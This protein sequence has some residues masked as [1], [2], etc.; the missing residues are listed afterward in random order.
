MSRRNHDVEGTGMGA[1]GRYARWF[2]AALALGLVA[3][4]AQQG[5]PRPE[6]AADTDALGTIAAA[7][8]TAPT[9][10]IVSPTANQKFPGASS[11]NSL[12][13]TVSVSNVTLGPGANGI[14]YFLD[15]VALDTV[16]DTTPYLIPDFPNGRRHIAAWL[17]D[18]S[19]TPLDV[20]TAL[21]S[22]YVSFGLPCAKTNDC[23]DGLLCSA[24]ACVTGACRFGPLAG[25]CDQDLE[26]P[27]GWHCDSN[28]CIE[29]YEDGECDDGD[30][31]TEDACGGDGLCIHAPID[32]CC[33]NAKQCNDND[34]CTTDSCVVDSHFCLHEPV[35]DPLCCN[36]DEDCRPAD[37][38]KLYICYVNTVT[39][40]GYHRCRY[41]PPESGCC[42]DDTQCADANPC[43]LDTCVQIDPLDARGNCVHEPDPALTECCLV[44]AD[45][46]DADPST[47]DACVAN[48]C[49]HTPS[50][51]WCPL[52]AAPALVINEL[53]VA[54]GPVDDAAGE[55]IE[56]YNPSPAVT[57]NMDGWR[58][59]TS[60]GES[61]L[62]DQ[63][64]VSGGPAGL[65]VAPR[66]YYVFGRTQS[67]SVNGGFIP[68]SAYGAAISLPDPFETGAAVVH[69]VSLVSDAGVVIDELTYDSSSWPLIDGHSLERTHPHADGS[70]VASWR[71]AGTS[72]QPLLDRT[73]GD[74][75]LGLYG[76]PKNKNISSF[77]GLPST[78]CAAEPGAPTCQGGVCNDR[79]QCEEAL[80][81]GCCASDADCDDFDACTTDACDVG[82]ETCLPAVPI[83]DCCNTSDQCD[84]GDPCNLD[85]C[86]AHECR[87]SPPII[88]GCCASDAD[89]QDED[90]CA[91]PHCNATTDT[92][93]PP[94]PASPGAG[95]QCCVADVDCSDGQANTDDTCDAATHLCVFPPNGEQCTGAA[96]PCDD[97]DPCTTDS[98][99]VANETCVHTPVP[100]CCTG[101]GECPDDGDLCTQTVCDFGSLSCQNVALL[102]CCNADSDCADTDDCTVDIC[103][104]HTCH[105]NALPG[106]C[107]VDGDC[108]DSQ[109]CTTDTC[110]G[111]TCEH[112]TV[113][114]C[115][116]PG[117]DQ[118][119]LS[120]QCGADPDGAA[121]CFGWECTVAG[122]CSVVENPDCCDTAAD[123]DDGSP[124]TT[125]LCPAA[126]KLCKH[127]AVT[128][129]GCCSSNLDC[130]GS[131]YCGANAVCTTKQPTGTSCSGDD[132]CASD[133]CL[134]GLCTTPAGPGASCSV[135]QAC[136]SGYC[137]DGVCCDGACGG[138][139]QACDLAG[140]EGLCTG[141]A[142][143]GQ[144]CDGS[145]ECQPKKPTGSGCAGAG[146][147]ASGVC[148]SAVCCE[149]ACGAGQYC[150]ASGTCQ[151][152]PASPCQTVVCDP[153]A[154]GCAVQD[155]AD[156]TACDDG[157]LCT[158]TD[159]CTSG[160]CVGTNPVVCTP[161]D[162]CHAA[163]VCFA[164][165]GLCSDPPAADGVSCD[166]GN[167]CTTGD[168][169]Q[170]GGCAPGTATV[171]DPLDACHDAGACDA[172][173]GLCSNPTKADGTACDIGMSCVEGV[174]E[175]VSTPPP[176]TT[177]S[178]L[179]AG[180]NHTC[181][182]RGDGSTACWGENGDG[183]LGLGYISRNVTTPHDVVGLGADVVQI[184]ASSTHTCALL[185]DAT[186]HCWGDNGSAQLGNQVPGGDEP[187]PVKALG[188]GSVTAVTTGQHH[189]CAVLEDTT[190]RCWGLNTSDELGGSI[191]TSS[192]TPV[193]ASGLVGALA[194]D[195]A[196]THTCAL[197]DTGAV[198]CWGSNS[199]GKSGQTSGSITSVPTAVSGVSGASQV[200]V[201]ADHSC[202]LVGAGE[203][204]CWGRGTS[205]QLGDGLGSSSATPVTVTGI[206]DAT[207]IA[208]GAAFTCAVKGDQTVA[209]WGY[210]AEYQL[211]DGSTAT[212]KSPVAVAG[213][214]GA[215]AVAAGEDFA[216]ALLDTDAVR[217]WGNGFYGQLGDGT[218]DNAT[219][220]TTVVDLTEFARCSACSD[221]NVCT[222][223]LCD[224]AGCQHLPLPDGTPCGIGDVCAAGACVAGDPA[225]SRLAMGSFQTM[226][227]RTDGTVAA[228]GSNANGQLGTGSLTEPSR[229]YADDVP[230]LTGVHSVGSGREQMCAALDGGGLE[231]WGSNSSGQLG[232]GTTGGEIASPT[233][234]AGLSDIIDVEGGDFYTC[235]LRSTGQV[236]CWGYNA[237]GELGLG[238]SGNAIATPQAVSGLSDAVQLSVGA[239][240]ACAVRE[241]GRIACWGQ[242]GSGRLGNGLSFDEKSPVEVA[243]GKAG[244]FHA[245]AVAAGDAH[246]CAISVDGTVACWGSN[247]YGALGDGTNSLR[248]TPVATSVV[249]DVVDLSAGEDHT[250]AVSGDGSLACWGH[251]QNGQLGDGL[252]SSRST[253]YVLPSITTAASVAAARGATCA[254]LQDDTVSCWGTNY[255]GY[256][257]DGTA[258][259]RGLPQPVVG[260]DPYGDCAACDDGNVCTDDVCHPTLGCQHAPAAAGLPCG[261]GASCDASGVCSEV[262]A[263]NRRIAAGS[264]HVC[265]IDD[266]GAVSCWGRNDQ[267]Q[268]GD[269]SM[270][271]SPSPV[272]VSLSDVAIS[273]SSS[274]SHTCALLASGAVQCWGDNGQGQLGDGTKDDSGSPVTVAG[275]SGAVSLAAGGYHTCATLGDGTARCWGWGFGGRL[276]TGGSGDSLSPTPVAVLDSA[277]QVS[278]ALEHSC[279]VSAGGLVHCWGDGT[280]GKLGNASSSNDN[281]SPLR[282]APGTIPV[283]TASAVGTGANHTCVI[284][285][286]G[287]VACFGSGSYNHLGNGSTSS[288]S[289]PVAAT[290]LSDALRLSVGLDHTCAVRSTGGLSCWGRNSDGQMGNGNTN[291]V[292][293]PTDVSGLGATVL[294]VAAGDGHTCALVTGPA[295]YC[296]GNNFYG[297]LGQGSTGADVKVP[298]V[299]PTWP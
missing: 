190:V 121:L 289:T 98:C 298:T 149:S 133:L 239:S 225:G 279:S 233:A 107:A 197:L 170:G 196:D 114:S 275:L 78:A 157:N 59:T 180:T 238:S 100:G 273:V 46:D 52:P 228:W 165:T 178:R 220:P 205:G 282:I 293:T 15:G 153:G 154:P 175:V 277:V 29:C 222:D 36:E 7:A 146:E 124:C 126:T 28:K 2:G 292:T 122:G 186:M 252:T 232:Q 67:K 91:I 207:Q 51:T 63:S 135:G 261:V 10:K 33:N 227:V 268:L 176:A 173:T 66:S 280:S 269:G 201:G 64:S 80:Q 140:F 127:L 32:G 123:C 65:E 182:V 79:N 20:P 104:G 214:S 272:A 139:C 34:A 25:C 106:C 125:D 56:L 172:G 45:C 49:Q 163:G 128:G 193:E 211:G 195:A 50:P 199:Y 141:C 276:G 270:V 68:Q 16:E 296:W 203:V 235:A 191:E 209:C 260:L 72:G 151:A 113:A 53:M 54:P 226:V 200:T 231:C 87:H 271:D 96:D 229:T 206:T 103:I 17:V 105:N 92:C 212:R 6:A 84:D 129:S 291:T 204:Q 142:A 223:D 187:T 131:E 155:V 23:S 168:T 253:P 169:C 117:A 108:D 221:G 145:S 284:R 156:G 236:L 44:A 90:P 242:G 60:L 219:A 248:K 27:F 263:T 150:D 249:T 73:Y 58:I 8:S 246:T 143:G 61:F 48:E 11:G 179:A 164:L 215:V 3:C 1:R 101:S 167:L 95:E 93:D 183:Q 267:G 14:R 137:V 208:A 26:C 22:L 181:F 75:T 278:A 194:L 230:G 88:P 202:A 24:E 132:Q 47:D 188:L 138:A 255:L 82:A 13:V 74:K 111:G 4:G 299:V 62:I 189:S 89:C 99:D 259:T 77:A 120:A 251:D 185:S 70:L 37:S 171:C 115:C 245:V 148:D 243:P 136:A 258:K 177:T 294:D 290:G 192:D 30:A 281:D 274:R 283:F 224:P 39:N 213:I 18:S 160:A 266:A 286:G 234:V 85:R 144:F 161:S 109:P 112:A 237:F 19:G 21:A 86:I 217:C 69:T 218:T 38:C 166:D 240:H 210:N 287:A 162:Q 31:C 288:E 184:D 5:E 35:A 41:G 9:I 264:R 97:L 262:L 102:G 297:E 94:T 295:V 257:G 71:A 57:L 43:T 76:S 147:C 119:T 40:G 256:L 42:T 152:E 265:V 254:L 244:L 216:C 110:Q 174:C 285:P 116:T 247:S 81:V 55:W 118:A 83:A 250:C 241:G 198:S 12:T 130:A 158:Q 134:G 159:T